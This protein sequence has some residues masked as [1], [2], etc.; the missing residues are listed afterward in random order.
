MAAIRAINVP[1]PECDEEVEVPI[2]VVTYVDP[3]TPDALQVRMQPDVSKR[4]EH[5]ATAHAGQD[6]S[7]G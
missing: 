7:D 2:D 1:C 5:Y 4:A 6:V 3:A